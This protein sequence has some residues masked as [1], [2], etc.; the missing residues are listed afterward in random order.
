M[1]KLRRRQTVPASLIQ[2]SNRLTL[3]HS[4]LPLLAPSFTLILTPSA[5]YSPLEY[6]IDPLNVGRDT[7][8][9]FCVATYHLPCEFK[10][11]SV[12]TLHSALYAMTAQAR[13]IHSVLIYFNH[14][15]IYI[16]IC[17]NVYDVGKMSNYPVEANTVAHLKLFFVA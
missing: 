6:I 16:Y 4:P 9:S 12:I 5:T 15:Y 10:L 1:V 8:A 14:L 13:R 11:K 3:T 17:I 7:G 2:I